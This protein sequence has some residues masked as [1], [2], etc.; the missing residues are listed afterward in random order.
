VHHLRLEGE[1]RVTRARTT[2]LYE[3]LCFDYAVLDR[4][5]APAKAGRTQ[6]A[7]VSH[8]GWL[9]ASKATDALLDARVVLPWLMT[10]VGAPLVLLGLLVPV[11][12][13]G[14]MLPQLLRNRLARRAGGR[15]WI[16]SGA[17][18]VQ[19]AGALA[20][21]ATSLLLWGATAGWTILALAGVYALARGTAAVVLGDLL[22][23]TFAR[24]RQA[25]AMATAIAAAA[26]ILFGL[27]LVFQIGPRAAI[28]LWAIMLAGGL[29]IL[30][31]LASATLREPAQDTVAGSMRGPVGGD[32]LAADDRGSARAILPLAPVVATALAPPFLI[33][34]VSAT[35]GDGLAALGQLVLASAFAA[36]LA[37]HL[38]ERLADQGSQRVEVL[39][40]CAAFGALAL[41]VIADLADLTAA[42][43]LMPVLLF[44][45]M[46]AHHCLRIEARFGTPGV[47]G[48]PDPGTA[49]FAG[50]FVFLAGLGLALVA[51]LAGIH[52]SLSLI[53][54]ICLVAVS[55]HLRFQPR[56]RSRGLED[57]SRSGLS[58]R[59]PRR[60]DRQ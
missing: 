42:P 33:A 47:A 46:L 51:H 1:P 17:Y 20:I 11:R 59:D 58:G 38:R 12:E 6:R 37:P 45:L 57:A 54:V 44:V 21:A 41:A 2:E 27:A 55:A 19:G 52:V 3:T 8:V 25:V 36:L 7:P 34:L 14:A 10:L 35:P 28:V 15:S 4:R 32:G 30:A 22:A 24:S 5:S 16:L 18:A 48:G 56:R 43:F 29:L 50:G 40:G 39:F 9:A 23:R 53:A 49:A 13:A 26:V 60:S 31:G